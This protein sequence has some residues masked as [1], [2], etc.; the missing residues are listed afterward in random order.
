MPASKVEMAHAD[1]QSRRAHANSSKLAHAGLQGGDG[2]CRLP[3][4]EGACQLVQAGACQP[5][6]WRWR[7]PTPKAGG[8]MPTRP[9]WRMPTFKVEMAHADSQSRRAHAN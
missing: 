1:S 9:S 5:S 2:A 6:R 3:K 4:Q 7:M 8:R